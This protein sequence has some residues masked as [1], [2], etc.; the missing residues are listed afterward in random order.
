MP[1][2]P[3]R[4]QIAD[5]FVTKLEAVDGAPTFNFKIEKVQKGTWVDDQ[6]SALPAAEVF[7]GIT[8]PDESRGREEVESVTTMSVV[9]WLNRAA[10]KDLGDELEKLAQDILTGILTDETLGLAAIGVWD[11]LPTSIEKDNLL[12][13]SLTGPCACLVEFEVKHENDRTAF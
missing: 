12:D 6:T 10:G 4:T 13:D 2:A 5:A 3:V 9:G 11:V 8:T 1:D 7:L